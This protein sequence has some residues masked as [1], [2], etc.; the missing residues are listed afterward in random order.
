MVEIKFTDRAL[1]DISETAEYISLNSHQFARKFTSSII[2]KVQMLQSFPK[3]GRVV[4]EFGIEE[5]R[6]IFYQQYRIVYH[7]IS[8]DEIHILT[9]QHSSRNLRGTISKF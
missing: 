9:V 3:I 8:D 1:K 7:I 6:E 5:I 4:D 2:E